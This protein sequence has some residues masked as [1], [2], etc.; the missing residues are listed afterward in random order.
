MLKGRQC[1]TGAIRWRRGS[2]SE[3]LWVHMGTMTG[4][5]L[6]DCIGGD[7]R[8]SYVWGKSLGLIGLIGTLE[9]GI[10]R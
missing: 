2:T 10:I 4:K 6:G 5:K 9:L 7:S 1:A 3:T 8:T